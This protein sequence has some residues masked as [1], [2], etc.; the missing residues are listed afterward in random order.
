MEESEKDLA[1]YKANAEEDYIKVPI[2]VLRYI[3]ELETAILQNK[4]SHYDENGGTLVCLNNKVRKCIKCNTIIP[5]TVIPQ[6]SDNDIDEESNRRYGEVTDGSYHADRP[7][8]RK[9]FKKGAQWIRDQYNLLLNVHPELDE[10]ER[11]IRIIDS[12]NNEINP[13]K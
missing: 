11:G 4:C 10:K 3:G 2:S 6:I 12:S 8:E 7:H 1:Y 9:I 13:T 5:P